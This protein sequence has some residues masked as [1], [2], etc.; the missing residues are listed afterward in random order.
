MFF[1]QCN[2]LTHLM[3]ENPPM[4]IQRWREHRRVL[5]NELVFWRTAPYWSSYLFRLYDYFRFACR[6]I[7]DMKRNARRASRAV[8]WTYISVV[9]L[10][11]LLLAYWLWHHFSGMMLAAATCVYALVFF[12]SFVQCRGALCVYALHFFL[13]KFVRCRRGTR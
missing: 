4:H 8:K 12:L 5:L 1:N 2:M 3:P 6:P 10:A 9:H 11:P 13:S 7:A